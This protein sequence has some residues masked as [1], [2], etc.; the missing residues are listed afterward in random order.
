MESYK[1]KGQQGV[2]GG[3]IRARAVVGK[4]GDVR[5]EIVAFFSTGETVLLFRVGSMPTFTCNDWYLVTQ[6]QGF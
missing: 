3:V 1:S 6:K 4:T 5:T 2:T